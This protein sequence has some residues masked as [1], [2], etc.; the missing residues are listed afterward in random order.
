MKITDFKQSYSTAEAAIRAVVMVELRK[1]LSISVVEGKFKEARECQKAIAKTAVEDFETYKTLPLINFILPKTDIKAF[2][3]L[4]F[5]SFEFKIYNKF[6][7]KTPEEKQFAKLSK[8]YYSKLTPED[9]KQKT[10]DITIPSL[11]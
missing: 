9:I 1:K 8:D 3:I 11:F 7:K 4:A 6:F 2:F 10:I 5:K